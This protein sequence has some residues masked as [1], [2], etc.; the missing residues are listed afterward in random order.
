MPAHTHLKRATWPAF[1]SLAVPQPYPGISPSQQS[2]AAGFPPQSLSPAWENFEVFLFI[3]KIKY[4]AMFRPEGSL[5]W[6][7]AQCAFWTF[8]LCS[9]NP[10]N[11]EM[12]GRGGWA[13]SGQC[14]LPCS[15]GCSRAGLGGGGKLDPRA[16]VILGWNLTY[17]TELYGPFPPYTH[18]PG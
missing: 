14:P 13:M 7:V 8:G 11:L 3:F 1:V 12:F 16:G 4:Y 5:C 15:P 6:L 2:L 18:C 9:H 17:V 10:S